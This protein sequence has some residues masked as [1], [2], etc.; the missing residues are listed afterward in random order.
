MESALLLRRFLDFYPEFR[1]RLRRRL[2]SEDLADEALNEVYLK[3]RRA[4]G[5]YS[6]RNIRSYLFKLTLNTAIDQRRAGS[7]L[8][9]AGEIGEAMQIADPA[10]DPARVAED[11]DRLCA[12]QSAIA[13]LTPRRRVILTAVRMEG[14]SCRDLAEELGISKRMVEIELRQALDHCAAALAR[15]D[16][17]FAMPAARTSYH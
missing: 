6:I 4:E 2:G 15:G 1:E 10:P 11:R 16:A 13:T 9:S 5:S 17:D 8:A 12:L 14:R 3:L 7:R